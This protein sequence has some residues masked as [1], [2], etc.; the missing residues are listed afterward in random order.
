MGL[1]L[2]CSL[3]DALANDDPSCQGL[4]APIIFN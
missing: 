1:T 4:L 3:A 2:F